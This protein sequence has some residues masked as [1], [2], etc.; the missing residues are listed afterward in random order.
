MPSEAQ[1]TPKITAETLARLLNL[2]RRARQAGD[3]SVLGFLAVNDT[4]DLTPYR[5]AALWSVDDGIQAV[6]GVV[7]LEANASYAQWLD[8]VCRHVF[9][10]NRQPSPIDPQQLPVKLAAEWDAWLPG[11]GLWL[12][13]VSNQAGVPWGGLLLARDTPWQEPEIAV[14]TEWMDVWCHARQ[15]RLGVNPWFKWRGSE[16]PWWK[17]RRLYGAIGLVALLLVPVRLTVLAPGELVPTNPTVIRAPLEGVVG[18][19]LV[20]P[21]EVVK[22]GQ[23]LFNFDDA[24]L[25][26]RLE[27]ARQALTGAEA[28]YRQA[29]QLAVSEAK[30]KGQLALLT[31]KVE[32]RRAEADYLQGQ[33]ERSHVVA[34][35]EG[36]ALFDDPSE[37]IGK[38]VSTGERIM[39]IA[40]PDDVEVEAWL[41]VGDAIPLQSGAPV[42]LYLNASPLF[43]VSA[44][45]RYVAFDAVQRPDGSY[46]YRVRASLDSK[47]DHRVG[48]KGTAKLSGRWVPLGY[49]IGRRPLAAVRQMVGW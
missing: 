24:P 43:S 25:K 44:Q 1:T 49:W 4:H 12:P 17:R 21:N 42:S 23:A 45:V 37:W 40:A 33:L 35:H 47:T 39:R 27:V 5:Q 41:A 28:E 16:R 15:T 29:A 38:P 10:E 18:N 36:I 8:Q 34:P 19:F 11:F 7:Q 26:S 13:L 14:L 6:S 31:G 2:S 9:P 3:L 30:Y 32:E 48:L 46:A 22:A 20:K